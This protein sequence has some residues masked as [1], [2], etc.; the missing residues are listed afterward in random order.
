MS[1]SSTPAAPHHC[2][3][4]SEALWE[5]IREMI[6]TIVFAVETESDGAYV[7]DPMAGVGTLEEILE[8]YGCGLL[9][10]GSEIEDLY[11]A[12]K[13]W[14]RHEDCKDHVGRYQ[15]IVTSPP[16]DN[17][18]QDQYLGTP[19]EQAQRALTGKKPRRNGYAID[20]GRRVT[21]GSAAGVRGDDYRKMMF[22]IYESVVGRNLL[23]GGHFIVNVASSFVTKQTKKK[24]KAGRDTTVTYNPVAEWTLCTLL[25]LG[26]TLV[27]ARFVETPGY[28]DGQN[29]GARVG[30][31]MVYLF[32]RYL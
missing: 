13:P 3:K 18:M 29:R 30:G 15:L 24:G 10:V 4:F 11:A 2:A 27:D 21:E 26:L 8:P 23:P 20:L 6:S 5:P 25:G 22:E 32:R 31:E 28:R 9:P 12:A 19:A 7:Y 17:R 16:Y 14:I 1:A